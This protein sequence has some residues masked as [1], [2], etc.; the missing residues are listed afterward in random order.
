MPCIVVACIVMACIFMAVLLCVSCW[1]LGGREVRNRAQ[2]WLRLAWCSRGFG[3]G[4]SNSFW[5]SKYALGLG[6]PAC[7]PGYCGRHRRRR[8]RKAPRAMQ[9][10]PCG[11]K[12]TLLHPAR[13][14]EAP[15]Y[16]LGPLPACDQTSTVPSGPA[17]K[18]SANSAPCPGV[19][20][21]CA[22]MHTRKRE[23]SH[24]PRTTSTEGKGGTI[25][26]K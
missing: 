9:A 6:P 8:R 15:A 26:F 5:N 3:S 24:A 23:R 12:A 21:C 14:P 4:G 7:L 22:Q 17:C 25:P 20:C 18:A 16:R 2:A 13:Y 10:V 11:A 1:L 19:K